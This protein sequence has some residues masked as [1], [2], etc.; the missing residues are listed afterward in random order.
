MTVGWRCR[1]R[2]WCRSRWCARS[3]SGAGNGGRRLW[4]RGAG[5][6]FAAERLHADDGADHA[7]IDVAVA[8]LEARQKAHGLVDPAVDAEAQAIAGSGDLVEGPVEPVGA[9]AHDM[10]DRAEHLACEDARAVDLPGLRR[11]KGAVLG[12][13]RHR[14]AISLCI[15]SR[16]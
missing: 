10:Q 3:R 13:G 5:E 4:G 7:A 15:C 9:P 1:R 8:D 14:I 11:E 16:P 6:A 12:A 2:R